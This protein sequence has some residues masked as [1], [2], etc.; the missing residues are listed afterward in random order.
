M[1]YGD[2]KKIIEGDV[3]VE[4]ND[5]ELHSRDTSIFK[6]MPKAV[7][8]PKNSSD[9]RK[10][11]KWASENKKSDPSLS[12]TARSAGSDM[13][14]GPLNESVIVDVTRYL[15]NIIE[16]GNDFA[17]T[18]PGVYYRDFEKE[19]AKQGLLFPPYPASK[20]ICAMGG[21]VANNAGGEK[22]LEYG[23]TE[24]YVEELKI[25]LSD[26]NE[27][28]LKSLNLNELEQKKSE[29]TFEGEVYRSMHR[30]VDS[31][32]ELLKKSKPD[33]SKN[34][35][36]YYLWNIWDGKTFDLTKL[37]VGSQGTLGIITQA[38]LKLVKPKEHSALVVMFLKD[39][40][41]LGDIV[42]T[43]LKYK[44]TSLESYDDKTFSV[45]MKFLPQLVG[46]LGGNL[47]TLFFKFIPEL[48]MVLTGGVPKLVLIAEFEGDDEVSVREAA[49]RTQNEIV[50]NFKL[51]THI[52]IKKSEA[53]KYWTVRR[54]S[55]NLLRKHAGTKH[56]APFI[57]DVVVHPKQLPEFLPRLSKLM[58]PYPNL[59]Y[60]IAGHAGD[61]NFHI[62]PIMD[63]HNPENRK[64]ITEL[65][66]K[67]YDLVAEMHG[68]ITAEHNDGI[69]RTPYLSKM[70]SPEV[71]RLF[72]ETKKI[73]DPLNIFNPGKKVGGSKEYLMAHVV[74]E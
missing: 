72:E 27:Y 29:Q 64:A 49:D 35:A 32:S 4:Q 39:L 59:L 33:V 22:S 63:F 19:V 68:S 16:I 36:G 12:L 21:I 20:N 54:E 24:R 43:T 17:I 2:I 30:L 38:K 47:I 7:V 53:E 3:S 10:L 46:Q 34:S 25:V 11:V 28:T 44:P 52:V 45:A 67:V 57:D 15:K 71:I 37:F 50:S 18:E 41:S 26:G 58:E 61:A 14:G 1:P 9:I 6:V 5:L 56:T 51:K 74:K 13:S 65:S 23:K 69:I 55:F 70:Y 73:F 60:T 48:M 62:V 42:M 8:Y 31:N 66:E 40:R